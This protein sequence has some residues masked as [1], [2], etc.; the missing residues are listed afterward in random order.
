MDAL[1]VEQDQTI[2]LINRTVANFK[3]IGT[4]NF[5]LAVAR[6]RHTILNDNWQR[7]LSLNAQ[8]EK[9]AE[10]LD[11]T[12]NAYFL[13]KLFLSTEETYLA[14]SDYFTS[15]IDKLTEPVAGPSASKQDPIN[16]TFAEVQVNKSFSLPR[17]S[18]PKFSGNYLDWTSFRDI[19]ESL[20]VKNDSLSN[21]EKLHHLKAN[22]TN[23]AALVLK[24]IAVT[25]A[26]YASAW[27]ALKTRFENPRAIV[28][29]H[30]KVLFAVPCIKN[31]SVPELKHLRDT[32][33]D[34]LAALRTLGRQVETW[35]DLLVFFVL[36]RLDATSRRDWEFQLGE[37]SDFP[38]YERLNKFI[39]ARIRALETIAVPPVSAPSFPVSVVKSSRSSV[40]SS[41][42]SNTRQLTCL[43]CNG[44]HALYQCPSFKGQSID[45][46]YQIA[47]EKQCC[48]NCLAKGH[49]SSNCRSKYRCTHC[50][51]SHHSLLHQE[52][53]AKSS[54]DA[55][56]PP[57]ELKRSNLENSA[58]APMF[59]S[60]QITYSVS[61]APAPNRPSTHS[62]NINTSRA[63]DSGF[64]MLA[65]AI[66]K[67]R[68]EEGR[69]LC[70]RALIDPGSESTFVSENAVQNLRAKR[71]HAHIEVTG[72]GGKTNGVVRSQASLM[73]EPVNDRSPSLLANVLIVPKVTAYRVSKTNYLHWDHL[74]DLQLADGDQTNLSPIALLIGADLY[75]SILREGLRQGP[76]GSP[77]AQRTIFGWILTG[78]NSQNQPRR[79]RISVLHCTETP[80]LQEL[81]NRFWEI[82]EPPVRQH[83]TEDDIKCEQHF[84]RTH[85]RLPDGRYSVR[86]P[87]KEGP[88]IQIGSSRSVALCLLEKSERRLL[89][90]PQ[91]SISYH[92]F[93]SEY[94]NLGHMEL[95]SDDSTKFSPVYLPHHPIIREASS[96]TR[97]RVVF[98]ASSPTS[99]G[100]SLNDH[101]FTGPKLQQDLSCIIMRWRR[102]RLVV[103]ADIEKM[104]RQI[105]VH[106]DDADY[107]R[108]LWR[109]SPQLP[110]CEY[111]LTT[112]TYGTAAAP[113]LANRVL[114]QLATDERT[115]FPLAAPILE[116]DTYVDDAFFGGD[117]VSAVEAAQRQLIA[118]LDCGGFTLRK[119][120]SNEPALLQGLTHDENDASI[121]HPL[122]EDGSVKVLGIS[123]HP[124]SDSLRFR[125][126]N[127]DVTPATKR[128]VLSHIARLFDPLGWV[129]PV[130]IRAKI[131]MQE[132]WLRKSGWDDELPYDLLQRW[133]SY[134][135]DLSILSELTIPRWTGQSSTAALC[136]VHG[137]ADASNRAYGAVVYIRV[138]SPYAK[139]RITLLISKTKVA[140]LKTLSIPKLEL[141]AA[142]LLTKVVDTVLEQ[143]RL[144]DAPV[145]CWSDST[146]V[147]NWISQH[148]S[149]WKTFVANRTSEIQ[150]RLPQAVW[151]HV[152]TDE[153]PADCASRGISPSELLHHPLWWTGPHWL[154]NEK[155]DW[156]CRPLVVN[157]SEELEQRAV[158]A[159]VTVKSE[160]A[161]WELP[162]LV[163]SWPRLLR[164]TAY[165]LRFV[166]RCRTKFL[167]DES[168]LTVQD[169][170]RARSFWIKYVQSS[171]FEKEQHSLT[172]GLPVP[173]GSRLSSLNPFIDDS[174]ILR[175][176]GRL[177]NAP[178]SFSEKHPIILPAHR[179]SSLIIAHMHTT[180]LHGGTQVTLRIIR[181]SYWIIGAR[182]LVKA[183][184]H[185]CV[186]CVRERATTLTQIMSDLPKLR[187]SPARPF[188]H[189]GVDYAGP[190]QILPLTR[191]GQKSYKAY[192]SVFICLSTRA[193]HLELVSDYSSE[194]FLAAFKRFSS[195]RGIPAT[196]HSDNGT[197][198]K[199]ADKE[200]TRTFRALTR[201]P[202]LADLLAA[203][204]TKWCFI[205]PSAPHHGG[206]WEAG[207]KSVK[208]HLRR[209][210]GARTLSTEEFCTLL[211]Q[212]EACL[213]SRPLAP[214]TDDPSD[215]SSLTPGHFLIGAP[216]VSVPDN[217]TLELKENYLSRWQNVRRMLE[218]FW[219]IWSQDYLHSLQQ[220]YKWR[221][222]KIDLKVNDLVLMKSS[223]LPPSK[224]EL[225]RI[226]EVHPGPDGR[227]RVV[228]VKT[229]NSSFKRPITQLC[230]LPCT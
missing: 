176:G 57:F 175:V 171:A 126:S 206:L 213:N 28:T 21:V 159:H 201:D 131:M 74:K 120:A 173:A 26:N 30:L 75:G 31:E 3:K 7:C 188:L 174:G 183:H 143:M 50:K 124:A 87:F 72:V 6:S 58:D 19:F 189:C 157:A 212:I 100:S 82:E 193:I 123:W 66:V 80:N 11:R 13:E 35:D 162:S 71:R 227:V 94:S 144:H 137:F 101:M 98:N 23:E 45:K 225:G 198:F 156:P 160:P 84:A 138:V 172:K 208:H 147:L 5:T 59:T 220:R 222:E 150:T 41:L 107:Q 214:L 192:I 86:L 89:R 112:V 56:V 142:F 202:N 113:F 129:S 155:S 140:P 16:Q 184:I 103:T 90:N 211:T 146:V 181:Q 122:N 85:K 61:N 204:G 44:Q 168:H 197:T 79:S 99:N 151:R 158:V 134:C 203:D 73:I 81:F 128:L 161:E 110:V 141:N 55:N 40:T 60:D 229:A 210:V 24:N 104:F 46:R 117:Q 115:R 51:R 149:R 96:T 191:R 178:L 133:S 152:M 127:P 139:P 95:A 180:C 65:T 97:V 48:L 25:D 2:G 68:S 153:N 83:L 148:P 17:I 190:I 34:S 108:I 18:L 36:Q 196:I 62:H 200:L 15:I 9:E 64:A 105:R 205:P 135:S 154:Q 47:R 218:S 91:L 43:Y 145:Y 209:V 67:L 170:D 118:L 14:A 219:R 132:L 169:F 109:S 185:R 69:E 29:S 102:H 32:M 195:R 49:L 165:V 1:L 27:E 88:P 52:S 217:S 223:L 33:N 194:K 78:P 187:V 226:V 182:T 130:V 186:R 12:T 163:S 230:K 215:L 106:S 63:C 4:K 167:P 207:V 179:I 92:E 54:L 77:T 116:E 121:V 10:D 37:S 42:L 22:L 228:T 93:L 125:V 114:R 136:E 216:L 20:V 221:A 70:V 111:R 119:W 224:W 177:K 38:T 164:V 39:A 8:I 76:L 166:D 53:F 199:G